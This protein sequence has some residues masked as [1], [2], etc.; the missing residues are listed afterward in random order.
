MLKVVPSR[1]PKGCLVFP[2]ARKLGGALM[3]E[4]RVSDELRSGMSHRAG[5]RVFNVSESA[6]Y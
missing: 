4:I 6:T 5:G 2:S 3:E 1:V